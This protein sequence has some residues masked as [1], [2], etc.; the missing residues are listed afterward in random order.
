MMLMTAENKQKYDILLVDD[1]DD[2]RTMAFGLLKDMNYSVCLAKD[3]IEALEMLKNHTVTLVI[4]DIRMPNMDG[5][6]LFTHLKKQNIPVVFI[7]GFSQDMNP[8][9]AQKMGAAGLLQKPFDIAEFLS[10]IEKILH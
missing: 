7:T 8:E 4:S 1:D 5:L 9:K 10:T 2:V 3:G 6:T